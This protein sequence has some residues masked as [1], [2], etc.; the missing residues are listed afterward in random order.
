MSDKRTA[1]GDWTKLSGLGIEL[2]AAVAGFALAG[3]WWDRHFGSAPWGLIA[4][5]GLGIVGGLYNVVRRTLGASKQAAREA[6]SD[7]VDR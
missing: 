6:K 4:G 5:S 2:A 3:L 7:E 1:Q